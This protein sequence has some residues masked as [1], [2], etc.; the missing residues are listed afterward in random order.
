MQCDCCLSQAPGKAYVYGSGHICN[1]CDHRRRREQPAR[2]PGPSAAPTVRRSH[3]RNEWDSEE[4]SS[5]I[6]RRV[7]LTSL[8]SSVAI[9]L[10]SKSSPL[11]LHQNINLTHRGLL[12]LSHE[13][14]THLLSFCLWILLSRFHKQRRLND[15][16]LLIAHQLHAQDNSFPSPVPAGT[17]ALFRSAVAQHGIRRPS[18]SYRSV[19]HGVCSLTSERNRQSYHMP[20]LSPHLPYHLKR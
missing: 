6:T 2:S 1:R 18:A 8:T 19:M 9:F 12:V 17:I 10:L 16:Q 13:G 14:A 15:R 11:P 20:P 7:Q 5:A 4:V 3:R